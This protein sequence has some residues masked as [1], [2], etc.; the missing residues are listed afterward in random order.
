MANH[1]KV[2]AKKHAARKDARKAVKKI[3][4]KEKKKIAAKLGKAVAKKVARQLKRV[5][6]R[7]AGKKVQKLVSKHENDTIKKLKAVGHKVAEQ[8]TKEALAHGKK[9]KEAASEGNK[10]GRAA[11]KFAAVLVEK[12]LVKKMG[13][14]KAAKMMKKAVGVAN[15]SVAKHAKKIAGGKKAKKAK[16]AAPKKGKKGAKAHKA[17]KLAQVVNMMESSA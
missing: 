13:S 4:R 2:S 12:S 1:K 9:K 15:K 10:A 6:R 11:V 3:V 8:I 17:K 5:G 7:A 16:K 14:K